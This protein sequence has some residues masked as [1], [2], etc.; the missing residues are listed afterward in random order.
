MASYMRHR[1]EPLRVAGR[2]FNSCGSFAEALS[3]W[4]FKAAKYL[5]RANVCRDYIEKYS[6]K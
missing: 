2:A 4:R 3:K 5:A 1:V 6:M